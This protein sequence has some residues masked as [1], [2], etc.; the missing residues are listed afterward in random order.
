MIGAWS[1]YKRQ[2]DKAA[3][4]VSMINGRDELGWLHRPDVDK[5]HE[6]LEGHLEWDRRMV[7]S[8]LLPVLIEWDICHSNLWSPSVSESHGENKQMVYTKSVL[9]CPYSSTCWKVPSEKY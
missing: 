3:D 9:Q 8:K 4:A 1:A 5:I 6:V 2:V 7:R